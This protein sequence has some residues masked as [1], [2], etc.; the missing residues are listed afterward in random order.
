MNRLLNSQIVRFVLVG[1]MNTAFSYCVYA[2]LLFAG[3]PYALASFLALLVGIVFSFH[4]QGTFVFGNRDRRRILRFVLA[5]LVIY[6]FNISLIGLML[7]FGLNAYW[8]GAVALVPVV[9][10]SYVVQKV[11]VFVVDDNREPRGLN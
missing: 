10:F 9:M 8:A 6:G 5:W 3:L 11:F 4:T 7:H 2:V 1:G